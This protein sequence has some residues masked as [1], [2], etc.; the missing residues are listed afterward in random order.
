MDAIIVPVKLKIDKEFKNLIRPLSPKEY[1]QLEANIIADGCRDPIVT[2]NG[3]IAMM[4][5]PL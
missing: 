1:D 3:F 2:W 5:L 4:T